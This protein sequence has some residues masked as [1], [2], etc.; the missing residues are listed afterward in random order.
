MAI[1]FDYI[2][3]GA[4]FVIVLLMVEGLFYFIN[5]LRGGS[6]RRVNRR[7]KM[8]GSGQDAET[9]LQKLRRAEGADG[10][11]VNFLQ[12]LIGTFQPVATFDRLIAHA[13]I[14]APLG[15]V[16]LG[17]VVLG[18]I[19]AAVGLVMSTVVT[20]ALLAVVCGVILPLT[21]IR[22][23]KGRRLKAFGSQLPDA[24]D[25]I[26]RS[27][28]AG[29]PISTALS[30][31]ADEMKDPVGT[32]FGIAIDEMTYGLDLREALDNMLGRTGHG[33]LQF[34]VAAVNIQAGVGGNL[35]EILGGL[36]RVIRDRHRMILKVKALSAEG[37]IS[38]LILSVLPFMVFG[39]IK[40]SRPEY[41]DAVKDDPLYWVFM[42]TSAAMAFSGI[43]IMVKMV[44]FRI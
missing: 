40:L 16:V 44:K 14:R 7:L 13:G 17:M 31:V 27:L 34:M 33:D 5:D 1:S 2:L 36:S 3:L 38:A 35:A 18:L 26:V 9:V 24:L 25:I 42:G 10:S 19:G 12:S 22:M 21:I 11:A 15:M 28:R 23:K 29:H 41:F 4:V 30:M 39:F 43:L 37:R 20:A 32:E 6:Q 8:L